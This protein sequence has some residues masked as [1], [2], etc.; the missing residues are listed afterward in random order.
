MNKIAVRGVVFAAFF[1]YP[2][3][4]RRSAFKNKFR[5]LRGAG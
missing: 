3:C 1:S 2:T 4:R 5:S